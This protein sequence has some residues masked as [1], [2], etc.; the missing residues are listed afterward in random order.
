VSISGS[1]LSVLYEIARSVRTGG[2]CGTHTRCF[3]VQG[4][5][6][7]SLH[8]SL[9]NTSKRAHRITVATVADKTSSTLNTMPMII[10]SG[11]NAKES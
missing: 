4:Q 10:S 3:A 7:C 8:G 11:E 6:A 1:T 2:F 5:L 9:G